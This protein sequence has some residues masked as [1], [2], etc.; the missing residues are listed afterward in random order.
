MLENKRGV[1]FTLSD[2]IIKDEFISNVTMS[3]YDVSFNMFLGIVDSKFDWF[4][5]PYISANVYQLTNDWVP[6]KSPNI[7]L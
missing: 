3:E 7:K 4:N 6:F 5:N 2:T 1:E